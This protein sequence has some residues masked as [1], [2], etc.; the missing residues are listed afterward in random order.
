MPPKA[1]PSKYHVRT[2]AGQQTYDV[3]VRSWMKKFWRSWNFFDTHGTSGL[4]SIC[5]MCPWGIFACLPSHLDQQLS[6]TQPEAY[7]RQHLWLRFF[8]TAPHL[9]LC[10][11]TSTAS[12]SLASLLTFVVLEPF[13]AWQTVSTRIIASVV[14][15]EEKSRWNFRPFLPRTHNLDM[16]LNRYFKLCLTL[17]SSP[18]C[19]EE[20]LLKIF[21]VLNVTEKVFRQPNVKVSKKKPWLS[22]SM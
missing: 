18:C 21:L 2:G 19:G 15:W 10:A 12:L 8:I 13:S 4:C 20:K 17:V 6:C 22:W 16:S 11:N 1:R 14:A 7:N 9:C 5:A 3:D